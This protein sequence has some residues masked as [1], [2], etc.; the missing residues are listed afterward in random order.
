MKK[1][2][3]FKENGFKDNTFSNFFVHESEYM[4]VINFNFK[5]GQELPVHAHDLEGE[6]TIAILE[7]QGEFVGRDG[8]SMPA[9]PGDVL[10]SAIAEPHGV[11]AITDLR[12][13]VTITPPI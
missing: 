9:M 7:G 12:V 11:R 1:I 6:L 5:A 2:E 4:K 10:V 13:L 3:L 8:A